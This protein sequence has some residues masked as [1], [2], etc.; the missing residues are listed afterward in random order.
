[1]QNYITLTTKAQ[2]HLQ[3]NL[4]NSPTGTIGV[5]V[6]LRN[7]GCSG[8]AY[9]IDFVNKQN[10]DEDVFECNGIKIIV[11]NKHLN[12]LKGSEIDF[13]QNGL[14]SFI[15]INNPNVLNQCGCFFLFC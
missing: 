1:M 4:L 11:A 13:V 9:T 3:E 8:F 10:E 7:A 14:N 5:R 12:A 2:K 6:G 15:K